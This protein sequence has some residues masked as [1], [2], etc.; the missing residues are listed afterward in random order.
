MNIVDLGSNI[1]DLL[2]NV[3]DLCINVIDSRLHDAYLKSNVVDLD[4]NILIRIKIMD[5]KVA[6]RGGIRVRRS[7]Y[8]GK[9]EVRP[10]GKCQG[11]EVREGLSRVYAYVI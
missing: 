10:P 8:F 1:V 7:D 2:S 11:G 9:G 5:L 6:V 3:A 4:S